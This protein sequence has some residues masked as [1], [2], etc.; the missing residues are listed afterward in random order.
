MNALG[1]ELKFELS[2]HFKPLSQVN[3]IEIITIFGGKNA[4]SVVHRPPNSS[5]SNCVIFFLDTLLDVIFF[6]CP[7]F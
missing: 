5:I 3:D 1:V 4:S 2:L 7:L 6:K